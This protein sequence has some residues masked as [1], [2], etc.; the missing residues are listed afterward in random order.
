MASARQLFIDLLMRDKTGPASK[1]SADN[2]KTVADAAADAAKDTE[3]LGK[4]SDKTEDQVEKL[5]KSARTAAEHV[6]RL[7]REIESVERELKQLAVAFA[8]AESAAERLD[9]SKAIRRTE[10]DL[11]KLK[12]SKLSVESLIPAD[13]GKKVGSSLTDALAAVKMGPAIAAALGAAAPF[14]GAT[15]SAAVIGGA[16]VGGVVGGVILASRDQRVKSAGTELGKNLLGQL[17]KSSRPFLDPVLTSISKIEV[18]FEAMGDRIG[19][20]FKNSSRFVEP[21]V[22]GVLDAVDGITRGVDAL[23]RRGGPVMTSL[24][25][26]FADVGDATG[27]A[28]EVISGGSED[29]GKAL[30]DL[31]DVVSAT[32][33][34]VG[35]LIRGLT[36]LYGVVSFIPTQVDRLARSITGMTEET[37]VANETTRVLA[38]VQ[39]TLQTVML[40]SAEAAGE[41]GRQ[42]TTYGDA[43][44]DA[45]AK[46]RGLYDSQ[47][48]VAQAVADTE[49]AIKENGKTLDA[50]TQ[51]GRDNRRALSDLAG[52]LLE[53]YS[54][55]V[56][57]NG[58]GRNAAGVAQRNRDAFVALATQFTKSKQRAEELATQLGLI[59]AKKGVDFYANTHDAAGRI[60]ALNKQANNAARSRTLKVRVSVS[61]TERLDDLGHRIGGYRAAGG[62]VKKGVP[63]VVGERRAE[64]FVPKEDGQIWPSVNRVPAGRSMSSS[65]GGDAGWV[66]VRGDALID[67]L[68]VAIASRVSAKGGRPAQLGIRFG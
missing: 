5:G 10:A 48:D 18:R 59:P 16:G 38:T 46:G 12:K 53:N 49:K 20:I 60:A 6:D 23:V 43:M 42:M 37:K 61:G 22:D 7:D 31:G 13:L 17:E 56:K 54:A 35:Y 62:P 50:N 1:S 36:E 58:E 19:R 15:L 55:Y 28:L 65:G 8:E 24:G 27:D 2:L 9:L 51:K 32:I 33:V 66:V 30:E 40:S 34:T 44:N 52:K 64:V 68:T 41:A 63:Y 29:A 45:A 3:Q 14:I 25:E 21:L 26:L 47:T 57:V 39:K 11:R 67:A 4:Q